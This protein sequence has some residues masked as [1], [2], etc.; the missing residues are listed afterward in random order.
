MFFLDNEHIGI[1]YLYWRETSSSGGNPTPPPFPP[2]NTSECSIQIPNYLLWFLIFDCSLFSRLLIFFSPSANF[3][4]SFFNSFLSSFIFST[5]YKNRLSSARNKGLSPVNGHTKT[6]HEWFTVSVTDHSNS[7]SHE[8]NK[9]FWSQEQYAYFRSEFTMFS[10][11]SF[12]KNV[13]SKI[14]C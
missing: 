11:K 4:S 10:Y 13:L 14:M 12:W 7:E 9:Q 5:F 1:Y 8:A 2:K 6:F 3:V